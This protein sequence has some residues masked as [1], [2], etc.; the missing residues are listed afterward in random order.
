MWWWF[1]FRF[2]RF[3]IV[4]RLVILRSCV[5]TFIS[6]SSGGRFFFCFGLF[7]YLFF[8]VFCLCCASGVRREWAVLVCPLAFLWF[9]IFLIA[10]FI[11]KQLEFRFNASVFPC[12]FQEKLSLQQNLLLH[13]V[14][15]WNVCLSRWQQSHTRQSSTTCHHFHQP[16]QQRAMLLWPVIVCPLALLWLMGQ[17]TTQ[18]LMR[19]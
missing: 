10:Q 2:P 4:T 8:V 18:R 11:F 12:W 5:I 3:W 7:C 14:P 6:S 16:L 19:V 17:S 15:V 9:M 13:C 1:F